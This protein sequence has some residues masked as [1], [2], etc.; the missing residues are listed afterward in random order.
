M[1]NMHNKKKSGEATGPHN[2]LEVLHLPQ[3]LNAQ[4]IWYESHKTGLLLMYSIGL[5]QVELR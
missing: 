3:L 5:V 4:G 2:V 1:L